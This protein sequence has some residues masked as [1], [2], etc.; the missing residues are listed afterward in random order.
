MSSK[1]VGTPQ[2]L[3]SLPHSSHVNFSIFSIFHMLSCVSKTTSVQSSHHKCMQLDPTPTR[4]KE[5]LACVQHHSLPRHSRYLNETLCGLSKAFACY[6]HTWFTCTANMLEV[7]SALRV[8]SYIS[9]QWLPSVS[10]SPLFYLSRPPRTDG[11]RFQPR[12]SDDAN[13]SSFPYK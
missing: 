8:I 6:I 5:M 3:L 1:E 10:N 13:V 7:S 9:I 12:L 2:F 11:D 4:H